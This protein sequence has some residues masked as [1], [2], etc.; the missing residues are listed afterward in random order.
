MRTIRDQ[1]SPNRKPRMKN[2]KTILGYGWRYSDE[3]M[4]AAIKNRYDDMKFKRLKR[5][6]MAEIR[7]GLHIGKIS[8]CAKPVMFTVYCEDSQKTRLK[9]PHSNAIKFTLEQRVQM[10]LEKAN[11][12]GNC[13]EHAGVSGTSGYGHVSFKKKRWY[14]HR[15]IYTGI[16]GP[17]KPGMLV[18]HR[19][20]N[21]KCINPQHLFLGTPSDNVQDAIKKGR[22]TGLKRKPRRALTKE[23]I[24]LIKENP[25]NLS[26]SKL[27]KKMGIHRMTIS[28]ILNGKTWQHV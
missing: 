17:I 25:E 28:N 6:V 8:N 18:C 15:L 12:V 13:L 16:F 11:P 26:L 21:K 2:A 20:D 14:A 7:H 1:T 22:M 9:R 27:S 23:E 10:L 4:F 5:E 19:C 24:L 3:C